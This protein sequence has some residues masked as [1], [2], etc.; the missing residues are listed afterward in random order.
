MNNSKRRYA[1]LS[2]SDKAGLLAF[3]RRLV[4]CNFTLIATGGTA[5]ELVARVH[6]KTD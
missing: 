2:V 1:L 5:K 3:A 6:Q 4:S